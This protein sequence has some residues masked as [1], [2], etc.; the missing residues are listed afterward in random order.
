MTP[1]G[2]KLPDGK[3]TSD[4]RKSDPVVEKVTEIVDAMRRDIGEKIAD[5]EK[6]IDIRFSHVDANIGQIRDDQKDGQVAIIQ[7]VEKIVKLHVENIQTI[8]KHQDEKIGGVQGCIDDHAEETAAKFAAVDA[9]LKDQGDR[10][11]VLENKDDKAAAGR[12]RSVGDKVLW[13]FI[14]LLL[15]GATALATSIIG[16][17]NQ[18]KVP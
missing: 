6:V 4:R 7:A 12:W 3:A 15:A 11:T 1:P 18:G 8:V 9:K 14:G 16:Q 2:Y 5:F 13:A 10:L 17:L